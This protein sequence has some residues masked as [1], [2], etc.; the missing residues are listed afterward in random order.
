MNRTTH[1][2]LEES[3]PLTDA[4]ALTLVF[5]GRIDNREE[6]TRELSAQAVPPRNRSDPEL[7]L[8][9]YK[10]WGKDSPRRLIGDFSFGIWDARQGALFCARDHVGA[11]PFYFV[12]TEK[13]FAFASEDDVLLALP[14][15]SDKPNEELIA[16]LLVPAFTAFDHRWSWRRDVRILLAAQSM[17]VSLDGNLRIEDYWRLELGERTGALSDEEHAS[18]FVAVFS[19]A[20]RCRTRACTDPAAMVSGGMDSASIVAAVRRQM[21]SERRSVLHA[22]S[23]IDDDPQSSI[24]SRCISRLHKGEN[25]TAHVV[26][27]PSLRGMVSIEDV[28]EAAWS[29]PHPIDNAILLPA[30]MCLAASRNG[31]RV[32]LHGVSGDMATFTPNRYIAFLLRE[33]Q[34][35]LAW[36]ECVGA[37]VNNPYLR[38]TRPSWLWLQSAWTA[39]VSGRL[40]AQVRT[41]RRRA[42]PSA[43]SQSVI[44]R[45]FAKRIG[46]EDRIQTAR[47]IRCAADDASV[48]R[49]HMQAL[50]SSPIEWGLTGFD[51]VAARYGVELRDPWADRRVVR[52]FV[53]LPLRQKVRFGWTKYIVR[54]TYS[55]ELAP[56]ICW[57][58]DKDHLGWRFTW[59]LMKETDKFV[60]HAMARSLAA[61]EEYIDVNAVRDRCAEER[62]SGDRAPQLTYDMVTL[63]LWLERSARQFG[64]ARK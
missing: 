28:I 16:H 35:P 44:N 50:A 42:L 6:L 34:W 8:C 51:R 11:R 26:S 25:S 10:L 48:A 20:V 38:T 27:I 41:L 55:D 43:I 56:E 31:H 52:F 47:G 19:E 24:E 17:Q 58:A 1:E 40:R 61:I 54:K 60:E 15:V 62:A 5:D 30:M 59:R 2:A 36:E 63:A 29:N 53:D 57:R 21:R 3:Q 12:K 45:G 22:Y 18:A 49:M 7:V 9:A 64:G 14:G 23:A 37:S 4:E 32:L 46:L 13:L 39:F 33:R